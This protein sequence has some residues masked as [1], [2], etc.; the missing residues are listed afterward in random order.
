MLI[1]KYIRVLETWLFVHLNNEVQSGVLPHVVEVG[2]DLV[3]GDGE[4]DDED[5]QEDHGDKELVHDPHGHHGGL[6]EVS[7][8]SPRLDTVRQMTARHLTLSLFVK[9][10]CSFIS[11][12]EIMSTKFELKY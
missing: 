6:E 7:A 2:Q 1:T 10:V 4:H 9:T 5:P 8:L 3:V 11:A 12:D